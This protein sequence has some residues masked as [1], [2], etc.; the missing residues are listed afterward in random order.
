M[1]AVPIG[2]PMQRMALA[3][4]PAYLAIHP[5]PTH[6]LDVLNHDCI[7]MR[8]SSGAMAD[9]EFY[10]NG[11]TLKIDP[12]ARLILNT[13]AGRAA[14]NFAIAGRGLIYSFEGWLQAHF[15]NGALVPVL[16]DWWPEF[17][18]PH[19]YFSSRFM[20]TPLRAFVDMVAQARAE[21]SLR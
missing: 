4:A 21:A 12:Q 14:T 11:E 6:P 13:A 10:K 2:P 5:P 15:D 1:I 19:L 16:S 7:R 9:W 20:P 8:F 17:K 18:G 3:A